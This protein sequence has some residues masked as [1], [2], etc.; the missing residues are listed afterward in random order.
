[1]Q[2][3]M[4]DLPDSWQKRCIRDVGAVVTGRTPSTKRED[5]YGGDYNLISPADLDNGKY[6][7]T[8]HKRLTNT[9]FMQC[10]A[11]PKDTVLVGCIGNVGKLGMVADKQSATNQQIN[12][13]I[14]NQENNPHFIYYSFH[15]NRSRLEQAADKTTVP[16]LNKTNFENFEIAVPPLAE[17]HKIASVLGLVQRA[18]EQQERLIALTT[19]LKKTLLHKL[20]AEGLRGE[21]QKQTDIGSVPESWDV[22]TLE[23]IA[24]A[25]DYGTSVKC[26]HG[27]AGA[28]VL[29]IPNVLGGSID[30]SDLKHGQPKRSELEQLRLQDGDLL[31]VRTNG[32]LE[33]A[34]RCALYRGELEGCYFASYLIRVRVDSSKVLPAFVNEYARTERGRSFLSGRA[35][36]TA[37]GKFNI[38]S[39]TLKRVLLP[40]PGLDEQKEF[41]RQLD[42]V[43]RKFTLH[44]SKRSAL[45]NLFRT[46]L[47]QLMTAQIRVHAFDLSDAK[48]LD[49]QS[50]I[51]M[52][53]GKHGST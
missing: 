46:L 17:Q 47:H 50:T 51:R 13:V 25:F 45:S 14:C 34:G 20:F 19:E 35:I 23:D 26:E 44:E 52:R 27:K 16:I 39:G 12:A 41:V 11:L 33:N 10:R 28:P 30:L 2:F 5:F 7:I 1:M 36:R 43:E 22:A 42:L 38:N 9:G 15:S 40:L 31:F 53:I 32:V 48:T 3:D 29:R 21:P 37:D 8:A 24:V 49:Q 6:V 4:T 18:L